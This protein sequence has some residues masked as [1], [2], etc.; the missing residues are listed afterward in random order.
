MESS[1]LLYCGFALESGN[2]TESGDGYAAATL[3]AAPTTFALCG[4][5]AG[6]QRDRGLNNSLGYSIGSPFAAYR[7]RGSR[8]PTLSITLK[9]LGA[10]SL[11]EK[12]NRTS[13]KLPWLCFYV[14]VPGV[15]TE[16]YRFCKINSISFSAKE[17]S[18]G[19]AAEIEVTLAIEATAVVPLSSPLSPSLSTLRAELGAPLFWHD[20]RTFTVAS[21][22]GTALNLRRA[23]SG[24][25]AEINHNLE[26]KNERNDFGDDEPLSNTNYDLLEHNITVSGDITL[27]DR[28]G[29]TYL[30]AAAR[31]QNWG[32]IVLTIGDLEKTQ[33]VD[34]TLGKAFPQTYSSEGVEA[35][36]QLS[37]SVKFSAYDYLLEVGSGDGGED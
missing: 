25:S 8:N 14:G 20:V 22:S 4:Y 30:T 26:R 17:S 5:M 31:S 33:T 37:H 6:P 28:L 7:K 16:A 21:A 35:G 10:L 13:N 2:I 34:L 29:E 24:F 19:E 11:L 36:A 9:G 23:I 27:H 32:N 1:H 18:K 15:W 3:P 12:A